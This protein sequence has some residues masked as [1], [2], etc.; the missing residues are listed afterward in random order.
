M[1][2]QIDISLHHVAIAVEDLDRALEYYTGMFGFRRL[3]EPLEVPPQRVKVCFVEAP[4]GVLI[5][6]VQPLD[7]RSPAR[8]VLDK[9]GTSPYHICY[10]VADM[11]AAI[12]HF[13]A[14]G[15]V[16]FRRFEMPAYG[17]R[18]FAFLLTPDKQLF[19]LCE[20]DKKEV[21]EEDRENNK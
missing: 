7:Q 18:R 17:L 5:E 12:A 13:K 10:K 21:K 9:C 8:K 19:E 20:E 6:L 16:P 2:A 11:D 4:P 3:I 14:R 15:C 1:N